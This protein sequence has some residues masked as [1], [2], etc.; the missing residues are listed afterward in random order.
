MRLHTN[1]Y[2]LIGYHGRVLHSLILQDSTRYAYAL[3][4]FCPLIFIFA[5]FFQYWLFHLYHKY[6][7]PWSQIIFPDRDEYIKNLKWKKKT[8]KPEADLKY[9]CQFWKQ[10][11]KESEVKGMTNL[12]VIGSVQSSILTLESV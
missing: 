5:P 4:T 10:V 2:N 3:A 7:H 12:A 6:G 9:F 1:V 8:E 11:E